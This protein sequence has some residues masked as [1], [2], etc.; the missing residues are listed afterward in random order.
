MSPI[1]SIL[2]KETVNKIEL[3]ELVVKSVDFTSIVNEFVL[4][5]EANNLD[6]VED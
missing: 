5:D 6:L 4:V 1:N 3:L 2:I